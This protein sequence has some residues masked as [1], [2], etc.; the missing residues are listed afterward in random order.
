VVV[1][2]VI[3]VAGV[4]IAGSGACRA[5]VVLAAGITSRHFSIP[6]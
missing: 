5:V 1:A 3:V 4:R 2:V 6:S